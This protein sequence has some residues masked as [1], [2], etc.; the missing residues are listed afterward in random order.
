MGFHPDNVNL[1][2]P[3]IQRNAPVRLRPEGGVFLAENTEAPD[4]ERRGLFCL[5]AYLFG[6]RRAFYFRLLSLVRCLFS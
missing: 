2:R 3:D 4:F 6:D 5:W 1:L